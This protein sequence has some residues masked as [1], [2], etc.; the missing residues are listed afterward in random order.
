M[1]FTAPAFMFLF[2]PL[3]VFFLWAFG[4]KRKRQ[5]LLVVFAVFH[6]FLY[7]RHPQHLLYPLL[8]IFYCY[9][10][11]FLIRQKRFLR[12][13]TILRHPTMFG[14][15]CLLPYVSL[16]LNHAWAYYG[17]KDFLYPTGLTVTVLSSTCYLL[18]LRRSGAGQKQ[19]L[20]DLSLYLLFFPVKLVGPVLR[21]SDFCELTRDK[22][23]KKF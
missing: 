4:K 5:T 3:A 17:P 20:L 10:A 18:E 19:N 13:S 14:L 1:L 11:V 8:L 16:V 12:L 23:N 9:G 21:Y 7:I 15:I 6:I 2:L 22:K